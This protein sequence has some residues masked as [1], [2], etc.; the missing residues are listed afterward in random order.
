MTQRGKQV[1]IHAFM[2][3]YTADELKDVLRRA[4]SGYKR[5]KQD[6]EIYR[7]DPS[8]YIPLCDAHFVSL[9]NSTGTPEAQKAWLDRNPEIKPKI[10]EFSFGGLRVDNP[11][12]DADED[13]FDI[14]LDFTGQVDVYQELYDQDTDKI[15]KVNMTHKHQHPTEAQF[16]D[17]RN[18]RRNKFLRKSTLWTVSEQHSTLEKLYDAIVQDVVGV[19]VN[20]KECTLSNKTEWV[21]QIPLW[22][23]IWVVDQI[24]NDLIVKNE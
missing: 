8:V 24:F 12:N 23:K 21:S 14:T 15:V 19:L 3:P 11:V 1:T 17:Y 18:A 7:E 16:R 10:V 9:G 4:V 22:H 2:T 13:V 6:V 5:E 20:N